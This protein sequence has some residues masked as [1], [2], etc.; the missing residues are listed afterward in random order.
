[1]M[2]LLKGALKIWIIE[3]N[4]LFDQHARM[5]AITFFKKLQLFT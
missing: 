4:K 3:I 2:A 1:M 5:L